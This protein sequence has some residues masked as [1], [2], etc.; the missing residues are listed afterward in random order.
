METVEIEIP[1][2]P[3]PHFLPLHDRAQRWAIAVCHR[4]AGKTVACINDLIKGALTC[5]REEPRFAY[6][7]PFYAQAKDVAWSYLKR[8]TAPIPGAEPHESE[9]RVDLPNGG[10]VRLYGLDNYD[11]LR[12][13]YF[14]GIVLDEYG[15]SDP[16]AW[17]E[18]IRPAL[19]DRQGWAIF[20][21]TPKG[22]NHFSELWDEAQRDPA[23]FS[24]M[25]PAS[26]SGLIP[27]AELADARKSMSEDQYEAEYECSF[28]A[29]VVGAYYGREMTAA[30][31]DKRIARVPWEPK[32]PVDTGWDLGIGDSTAIWFCQRYGKE[33]RL[34]DY[35]ESSGVGLDWYAKE[36]RGKP[37]VYGK[38]YLPHDADVKELGSGKS[39]VETL[40]SLGLKV[41]V[42]PARRKEDSINGVRLILP[43]CWFD[44][45]KAQRGIDCLRNYRKEFDDKLKVFRN[46][47][48]HD[49]SSHGA[50]AFAELAAGLKTA[51][52][53]KWEQPSGK[54]VI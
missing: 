33:I 15:D 32:L 49:W 1:Y 30:E 17:Q 38:H 5:G 28:Q 14:D 29:A 48:L 40:H 16:R 26:A 11:R 2:A 19:S 50:D 36:L 27:D 35:L 42:N 18:V 46:A 45:E 51:P 13:G 7:A 25:L 21:G 31:K 3:R 23:W 9:L 4:R 12:G 47:P 39:R 44:S 10:R 20:I 52:S 53:V 37:Y 41:K 8:F 24:V 22:R 34:I 54:W 6:C 43:A